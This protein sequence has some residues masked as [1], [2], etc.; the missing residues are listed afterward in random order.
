MEEERRFL[1][2][3]EAVKR[4]RREGDTLVLLDGVGRVRMRPAAITR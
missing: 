1:V 3:L 4:G 2:A